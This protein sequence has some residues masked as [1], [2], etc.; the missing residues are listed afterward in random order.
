MKDRE[1]NKWAVIAFII[2]AFVLAILLAL[3]TGEPV[4][5]YKFM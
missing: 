1:N 3:A 2:I 4:H 5:Y